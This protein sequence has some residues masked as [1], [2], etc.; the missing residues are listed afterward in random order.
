MPSKPA[1]LGLRALNRATLARQL[2]L[3]REK[4]PVVKAV[5]RVG[6]LQ[7]QLA[8]PVYIGLWSRLEGFRREVLTRAALRKEV[9]R[10]TAM[11]ATIH[12]LSTRD[13]RRWRRS[14][15]PGL[16]RALSG[17]SKKAVDGLDISALAEM[18]KRTFDEKPRTFDELR[19]LLK[20][21]HP[22]RNERSLAYAIRLHLPLVQI[23]VDGSDW[24]W[25]G[26]ADFAPA[27]A[28]IG[29]PL[30][31][32]DPKS[33]VR[34]YLAAFGPASIADA[35]LWSGVPQLKPVFDTLRDSLE[36]FR[37]E[38]GRELFDLPKAPRPDPEVPAPPRFLP[39]FDNVLL[40]HADRRRVITNEHRKHI[41][42]KNLGILPS[43]LVDGRFAGLW[44]IERKGAKATLAIRPLV[45]L[46][47]RDRDALVAEGEELLRFV[48][49]H[50][51]QHDVTIA[52]R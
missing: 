43:F 40:G 28:W 36:V 17:A 13:F 8:R 27:E 46:A 23:P 10:G 2:L 49:P 30:D 24:G 3:A 51:K 44:K 39:D 11:R 38:E 4:V 42:T 25:P 31:E 35:Q 48:E 21:L 33:L 14:L 32:P 20:K 5:E 6:G 52:P 41:F 34:S 19:A 26:S 29:A 18:A 1:V 50:A 47:R 9:V 16:S 15:Q 45:A 7:A 37:D 22:K 12:L